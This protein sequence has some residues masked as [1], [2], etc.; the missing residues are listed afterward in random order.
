MDNERLEILK[1][2]IENQGETFSIRQIAL[3][4]KINYKSAYV[5]LQ[6]LAKDGSVTLKKLGNT[7]ICSFNRRF[8]ESVFRVELARREELL[9]RDKNLK[10]L[11]NRLSAINQQF[12]LLLFGSY[13]KGM[14]RIGSDIDLLLISDKPEKIGSQIRLLPLDIHLTHIT[15]DDFMSM[16]RSKEFTVVSEATR[17]NVLLFGIEDYYRL[18]A[19]A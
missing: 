13:T 17:Y 19:N 3:R 6:S 15:Y 12:I 10:V 8:S 1:L 11:H 18:I 14:R 5:G 7:T 4:R 16:L 9:R 2:L